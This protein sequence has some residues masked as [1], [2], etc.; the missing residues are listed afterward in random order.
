[1]DANS[2]FLMVARPN[3]KSSD[4]FRAIAS[5]D[6]TFL[7]PLWW[8]LS[9]RLRQA[10]LIS[11][12]CQISTVTHVSLVGMPSMER[13]GSASKLAYIAIV[14][15]SAISLSV[16][17]EVRFKLDAVG[18]SDLSRVKR[19]VLGE[20]E[21]NRRYGGADGEILRQQVSGAADVRSIANAIAQY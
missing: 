13:L 18:P 10:I 7:F 11:P 6:G 5:A 17:V 12:Q 9:G 21:L 3:S 19:V 20:L 15:L 14:L 4:V 2:V 8:I 16:P 1:M